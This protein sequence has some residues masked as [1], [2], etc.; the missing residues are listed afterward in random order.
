MSQKSEIWYE[1][2]TKTFHVSAKNNLYD[3][4]PN[5][6]PPHQSL[7]THDCAL[8]QESMLSCAITYDT[9]SGRNDTN[10]KRFCV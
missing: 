8:I 10:Q 4:S 1:T 5:P 3:P 2:K 9:S 7:P 6:T